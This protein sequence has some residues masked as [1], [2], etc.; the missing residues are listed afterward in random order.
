MYRYTGSTTPFKHDL[1]SVME[2]GLAWHAR[3]GTLPTS[4]AW[5]SSL[6]RGDDSPPRAADRVEAYS[7]YLAGYHPILEPA[8]LRTWPRPDE[9]AKL[10]R[11]HERKG[12]SAFETY[13]RDV[14]E[15]IRRRERLGDQYEPIPLSPAH[16]F[17]C[18]LRGFSPSLPPELRAD[19][20]GQTRRMDWFSGLLCVAGLIDFAEE[21]RRLDEPGS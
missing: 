9:I 13:A 21:V 5:N 11:S 2:A 8:V 17:D 12:T 10:Y 7:R 1:D 19:V 16:E 14:R 18:R 6:A 4:E 3:Y 20:D 15:E